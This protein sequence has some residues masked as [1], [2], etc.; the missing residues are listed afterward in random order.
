MATSNINNE[1]KEYKLAINRSQFVNLIALLI[2][3]FETHYPTDRFTNFEKL[4]LVKLVVLL[5]F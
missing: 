2:C 3:C 1:L 4:N 5:W